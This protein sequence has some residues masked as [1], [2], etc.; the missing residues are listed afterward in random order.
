VSIRPAHHDEAAMNG[1]R[2]LFAL[3][4]IRGRFLN[5]QRDFD[6]DLVSY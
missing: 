3:N 2:A 1:A 4:G 5:F 6:A